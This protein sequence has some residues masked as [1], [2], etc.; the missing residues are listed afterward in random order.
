[1]KN[2]KKNGFWILPRY[3]EGN[4]SN[5]RYEK[6]Y[7]PENQKKRMDFGFCRGIMRETHQTGDT[8]IFIKRMIQKMPKR[9]HIHTYYAPHSGPRGE[10]DAVLADHVA[11]IAAPR[12]LQKRFK[13][14]TNGQHSMGI[15][16][17]NPHRLTSTPKNGTSHRKPPDS[18]LYWTVLRD[19]KERIK[20]PRKAR[21]KGQFC[22]ENFA[23]I[24]LF[25]SPLKESGSSLAPSAQPGGKKTGIFGQIPKLP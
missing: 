12:T 11:P 15:R 23:E 14:E 2:K 24:R 18:A 3:Y 6:I 1:M 16:A 20:R 25:W 17:R 9:A 13:D 4:G 8:K 7:Q 19:A 5:R 21:N 22:D 10:E